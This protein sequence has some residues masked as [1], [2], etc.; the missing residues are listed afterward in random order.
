MAL[1]C[2]L[3][4]NNKQNDSLFCDVCSKKLNSDFEIDLDVQKKVNT[5]AYID[6]KHI[7]DIIEP[8]KTAITDQS[9][10]TDVELFREDKVFS[11]SEFSKE[12]PNLKRNK[13]TGRTI[14]WVFVIVIILTGLFII[15]NKN[16][17][18]NS[19]ELRAWESALN[20]NSVSGYLSFIEAYPNGKHFEDAQAGLM[21]LKE[22]E[23]VTWERLKMSDNLDELLSFSRQYES[24]PYMPLVNKRI[25]SL[26]WIS[27]L[28]VNNADSYSEYVIKSETG[29]LKGDYIYEASKRQQMLLQ[30]TPV[31]NGELNNIRNLVSGFYKS[32]SEMDNTGVAKYLAPEVS[33]FYD[34]GGTTREKISGELILKASLMGDSRYIFEPDIENI[35]YHREPNS[36]YKVNIPLAKSYTENGSPVHMSGYIAHLE[37]NMNFEITSIYE[38]KPFPKTL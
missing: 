24:S 2:P 16:I 34:S 13:K 31:D 37:L 4:G 1:T 14:L 3:C 6:D 12:E 26:S 33:R 15:Y 22:D 35:Q 7:E 23:A 18:V 17:R 8:A 28:K 38:T 32:L 29:V 30:S 19:L 21:K 36:S 20:E 5:N 9:E 27:A 25:D 10:K 11:E